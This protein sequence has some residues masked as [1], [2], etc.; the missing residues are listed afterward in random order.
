MVLV[1][2]IIV[3]VNVK[4]EM[5]ITDHPMGRIPTPVLPTL[6]VLLSRSG[7]PIRRVPRVL[8]MFQSSPDLEVQ[9]ARNNNKHAYAGQNN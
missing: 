6:L 3:N 1:K 4:I 7:V 9:G 8:R 2:V 5:I